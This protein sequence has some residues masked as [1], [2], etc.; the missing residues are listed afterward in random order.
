MNNSLKKTKI[1]ATLGPASASAPV[2]EKLL[3]MGVNVFR[4]NFSH[5]AH[6]QHAESI[7]RVRAAAGR[8]GVHA[9]ILADLQGPKIRCGKTEGD[10][11]I[12]LAGGKKVT[13]T[14][15]TRISDEEVI[16]INYR[17]LAREVR[18]GQS[19]LLNDGAVRLR[20][21][22]VDA[23]NGR[24]LCTVMNTGVYS[25]HKGVNFPGVDLSVPALTPKDRKDL[26]FILTK[27][28]NYVALSFVRR[29]QDVDKLSRIIRKSG[30]PVKIIAKIEKPEALDNI[31]EVIGACD[32]IMV[33]RGDLGVEMS[34]YRI[35]VLQKQL[36]DAANK[37]GRLVIVATQMLESMITAPRPT[38]AELTDVANAVLDGAD[39]VM[40]SGETAIGRYPVE[41]VGAMAH[42]AAATENS[43]YFRSEFVN[44]SLRENHPPHAVCEA[45]ERASRDLGLAPV[46]VF[47][48]SGDTA[49]YLAK[50]RNQSSIFAFSPFNHVA[51][52][53]ALAWNMHSFTVAFEK[54]YVALVNRAEKIL[55]KKQLVKKGA[56][57]VVISGTTPVRGGAN[58]LRIKKIGE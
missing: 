29:R 37:A 2:V 13:L 44:L 7:D 16:Y 28:V 47:T 14:T 31:D 30:K 38:R 50:I 41:A 9:A 10:R 34:S 35:P 42:L 12:T 55:L 40:L 23:A 36:V 56:L 6:A 18:P 27:D 5:G 19:I 54:D 8:R 48:W 17:R 26:D 4:I 58:L 11:S 3:R 43:A 21:D 53:L 33:A 32:G 57:V 46:I 51:D 15:R 24:V 39:A 20:I 52:Q 1:V 25:S 22:T 45:T 49:F